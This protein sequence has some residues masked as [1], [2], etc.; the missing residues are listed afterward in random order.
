MVVVLVDSCLGE[1]K[2]SKKFQIPVPHSDFLDN[3]ITA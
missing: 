2:N 1:K 3:I